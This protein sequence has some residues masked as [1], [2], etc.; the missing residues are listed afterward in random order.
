MEEKEIIFVIPNT[1]RGPATTIRYNNGNIFFHTLSRPM[2]ELIEKEG[3]LKT[4]LLALAVDSDEVK[5]FLSSTE[6]KEF[7]DKWVG[8]LQVAYNGMISEKTKI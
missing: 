8:S 4:N 6:G 5:T 2:V 1:I 7:V 3:D